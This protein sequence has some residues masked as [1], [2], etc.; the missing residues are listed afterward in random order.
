MAAYDVAIG[1]TS[2]GMV[3]LTI[4]VDQVRA[5][6]KV[7]IAKP[8]RFGGTTLSKVAGPA[9]PPVK[10]YT[11]WERG[12]GYSAGVPGTYSHG[13]N[14]FTRNGDF[15]CPAGLTK[16]IPLP[17]SIG[18]IT[19][20]AE[21]GGQ[22]V[23]LGFNQYLLRSRSDRSSTA[24][25]EIIHDAGAGYGGR[26]ITMAG[27]ALWVSYKFQTS[28]GRLY[29][30]TSVT[31]TNSSFQLLA[32]NDEFQKLTTVEFRPSQGFA[33]GAAQ[34]NVRYQV[35]AGMDSDYSIA[36][37]PV[38]PT[39]SGV[40]SSANWSA[41]WPIGHAATAIQ[42]MTNRGKEILFTKSDGV[43]RLRED[44]ETPRLIDWTFDRDA[45]NG[46]DSWV[47]EG[48]YYATH[49]R[50]LWRVNLQSNL[51]QDAPEWCHFGY[52]TGYQGEI[53]GFPTAGTVD[54]GWM[55]VAYWN[56]TRSYIMYGRD[57]GQ[58]GQTALQPMIWH[59][60]EVLLPAGYRVQH[61]RVSAAN[62]AGRPALYTAATDASGK[63]YLFVTSLPVSGSPL[64]D[65]LNSAGHRFAPNATMYL[66]AADGMGN[67]NL[68]KILRRV[69]VITQRLESGVFIE[70]AGAMD[71][72]VGDQTAYHSLGEVTQSPHVALEAFDALIDAG[73]LFNLRANFTGTATHPAVLYGAQ[74]KHKPLLEQ[75]LV[76]EIP[77]LIGA[78]TPIRGAP[79][80]DPRPSDRVW[81]Q[82]Q[83]ICG[84]GRGVLRDN[85][86]HEYDVLFEEAVPH[87][88][89][90]DP[91]TETQFIRATVTA[92]VV[93]TRTRY[94]TMVARYDRSRYAR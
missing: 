36:Y 52:G 64:S 61:M 3:G 89:W 35:L 15:A 47:H 37:V 82:V 66:T 87:T 57:A 86:G 60:A 45:N 74:V 70:L 29:K 19:G 93:G 54:G 9:P 17:E 1:T 42:S 75:A 31:A 90:W 27:D 38:T 68:L 4:D 80:R 26:G 40:G 25:P 94:D 85:Q 91:E 11:G 55:A 59:G 6:G 2:S 63:G 33:S 83:D 56:G 53:V 88:Y 77:V 81:D 78:N 18:H 71:A 76:F 30:S 21:F 73:Y 14:L 67:R 20:S 8:L 79:G 84:A 28:G 44:G 39:S 49:G 72:G 16:Q 10:E 58:V 43:Y 65:L 32:I 22:I 12:A 69:D 50:G 5:T 51:R 23:W 24:Q 34:S 13:E 7:P 41:S 62:L 48:Y 46:L 92:E